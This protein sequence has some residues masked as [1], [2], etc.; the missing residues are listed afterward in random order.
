MN[1]LF[2]TLIFAFGFSIW[3]NAQSF[4]QQILNKGAIYSN[5]TLLQDYDG[6]GDMDVIF[7]SIGNSLGIPV[8]LYWFENEPNKQFPRHT[9]VNQNITRIRDLD[10]A[11]F[12][13][14]GDIDYLVCM[15][16]TANIE[17]DGELAWFQRQADGTYIKWTIDTGADFNMADIA[18]FNNDGKPDIVATGFWNTSFS[19]YINDGNLFF[20]ENI[21]PFSIGQSEQVSA[22]DMDND[23][24]IDIAIA[25]NNSS[26][27]LGSHIIWNQGSNV[28]IIGPALGCYFSSDC[29]DYDGKLAISDLNNDGINDIVALGAFGDLYWLSGANNFQ[30]A[31]IPGNFN[32]F[33]QGDIQISDLDGNG[34]KDIVLSDPSSGNIFI[35]HQ[36]SNLSFSAKSLEL[37]LD[38]NSNGI[39]QMEIGDLDGDGDTDIIVPENG[40]V[41]GDISWF[42]N[43]NSVF[44][45]HYINNQATA[46]RIPKFADIDN[47]GDEDILVTLAKDIVPENEV[48]LYE[49]LGDN[50]FINWRINDN[51]DYAADIEPADIDGDGDIDAFVTVRDATDL[52]WLKNDGNKGNWQPFIIDQNVNQALGMRAVDLDLDNDTDVVVCSNNDDKVFWYKN[53]G[54][55]IFN[56][57]IVDANVDAPREVEAA[58]LDSDGDIDLAVACTG[59]ANAV[60]IYINNGMQIFTKQV[61]F[62]GKTAYDIEI[63]DWNSDGKPDIIFTLSSSSPFSPQ[64]E[65]VALINNGGNSF[66][67]T[68]LVINAEKGTGLKVADLDNDGDMDLV[69]GRNEQARVKMWLQTPT[70]LVGSTISDA[71]SS[72]NTQVLGLDVADTNGDGK[73]EIVFADF[74][75]D[76]L[77][78]ISFNCF[79]GAILTTSTVNAACGQP[80]GSI[81]VVSTGGTDLSYLWSNG[82]TTATA[83]TLTPGTYTVTVTANGGCTSTTTAIVTGSITPTVDLGADITFQ[84]GQ[85]IVLDATGTGLSYLWSTGANTP[86]ITVTTMGTY[87]VIVTNSSGCTASD[88]IVVTITTS[89]ADQGNK[90]KISVSPN[91]SHDVIYVR[92][93][94]SPTISVEL[95]DNLGRLLLEDN[96]FAPDGTT[97]TMQLNKLPAGTYH[98]KVAGKGFVRTI[99]FT[100]Q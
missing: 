66:I 17:T 64:Q 41:D 54:T 68:P 60:V 67:T 40:N 46:I 96:S 25:S 19:T 90:Y 12:D 57:L 74:S 45:R 49:N 16:A 36:V 78:L 22:G 61:A 59:P 52:I 99:S 72:S 10:M 86:T 13:Q 43:I 91:P 4:T 89:T 47:D 83:E 6:D 18:D 33:G 82:A 23:G 5:V 76:E 8:G 63:A 7:T 53:D 70:G 94:G 38:A 98:L 28:F 93:E 9:I 15:Q 2:T 32:S 42:E 62:T 24:D 97:R 3:V 77:V 14:D 27:A 51:I 11:D 80:N 87:S 56:K 55:G 100:K 69:V 30:K 58:D 34:L 31:I 88:T 95:M 85:Q 75:R 44:F 20:T 71:G 81:T 79:T 29:G 84:Q 35:L 39:G 73:N 1:Q 37:N 92:C 48:M 50:N 26:P 21:Q 65:V